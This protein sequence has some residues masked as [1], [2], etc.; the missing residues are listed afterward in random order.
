MP[1]RAV[2]GKD[3]PAGS[4]RRPRVAVLFGGRSSEHAVSCVTAAGVLHAIDR[5]K[6]DVVPIGITR[7]GQWVQVSDDPEQ[8][9]LAAATLPEV[10]ASGER[11]LLDQDPEGTALVAAAPD[12][13]LRSLGVVDVVLPLLHGPFGE[14]GTLQGMLELADVRYVG[15]GVLASAVSMDKHYMKVVFESAGLS[16]GPYRVITDR[17]WLRDE[18]A[19]MDK[20]AELGFPVF[21]KPARAGSSMGISKVSSRRSLREAIEAAREHDPKV[22]VEAAIAG[23]EIECAVLQGRDCEPPRT[24]LPGEIA[25]THDGTHEF[26]DFNAKYVEDNA[27]ALSCP[28]DLPEDVTEQVRAQAAAAFDAVG[29]EGLSRVDF[30]YTPAGG[31]I[32]NEINTMPGFTPK[33]MYPQMWE[34]TG[35]PYSELIDELIHLALNRKVGLR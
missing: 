32:I 18:A 21:V 24:S 25:V 22:V 30:F 14:D 2:P 9:S 1:A 15:A 29:A 3:T 26:Y 8:W 13:V 19:A 10:T 20:V 7:Q 6:Y 17:Q 5:S 23:R 35:L 16:V 11:V 28:A 4:T 27:A 12:Q 31:L 34:K 33:S